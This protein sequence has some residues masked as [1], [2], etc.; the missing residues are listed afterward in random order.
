L[1]CPPYVP[2]SR[3]RVGCRTGGKV[4][5]ASPSSPSRRF[6]TEGTTQSDQERIPLARFRSSANSDDLRQLKSPFAR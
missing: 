6:R 4:L 2:C 3:H 1:P 5:R